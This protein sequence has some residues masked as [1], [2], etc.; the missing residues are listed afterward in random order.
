ML[1]IS[2][3]IPESESVSRLVAVVVTDEAGSG[4]DADGDGDDAVVGTDLAKEHD[5]HLQCLSAQGFKTPC[6]MR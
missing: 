5:E 3:D 4:L 1:E 2:T 6:S